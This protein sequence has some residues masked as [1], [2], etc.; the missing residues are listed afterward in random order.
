MMDYEAPRL[1]MF[2]GRLGGRMSAKDELTLFL[3]KLHQDA[4][5]KQQEQEYMRNL[6]LQR[7][8]SDEEELP[9]YRY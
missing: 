8:V 5:R 3:L 2:G 9:L 6:L 4:I 1:G 7:P